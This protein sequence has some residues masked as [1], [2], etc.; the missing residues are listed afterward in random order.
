MIKIDDSS[1]LEVL[2]KG[3]VAI[4]LK[5]G[6]LNYISDVLYASDICQ[7]LLSIEQI[8][9]KDYDLIF[10]RGGCTTKDNEMGI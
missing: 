1:K 9:E 4:R 8:A 5:D 7:N 10:N 6:S 3:N 2:G